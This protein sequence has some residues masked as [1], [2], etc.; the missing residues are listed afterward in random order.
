MPTKKPAGNETEE[1]GT[2]LIFVMD[3]AKFYN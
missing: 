3:Q 2:H 1:K